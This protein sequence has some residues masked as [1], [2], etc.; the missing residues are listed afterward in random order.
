MDNIPSERRYEHAQRSAGQVECKEAW[1]TAWRDS[2]L[3]GGGAEHAGKV[4]SWW[5][6][7]IDEAD[8]KATGHNFVVW[9][10]STWRIP[11]LHEFKGG[12]IPNW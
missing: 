12:G 10:G 8:P 6:Y 3:L 4:H 2:I 1:R 9:P 11:S 5:V 7:W